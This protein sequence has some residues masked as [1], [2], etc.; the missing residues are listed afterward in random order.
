MV[1]ITEEDRANTE[2]ETEGH[3][4]SKAFEWVRRN[5]GGLAPGGCRE[6][7]W[8]PWAQMPAVERQLWSEKEVVLIITFFFPF[9]PNSEGLGS[10]AS[11]SLEFK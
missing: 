11:C 4:R 10:R 8:R 9:P 3:L 7:R 5:N 2:E 6:G 1:A